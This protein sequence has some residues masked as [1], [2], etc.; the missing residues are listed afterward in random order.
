M[1]TLTSPT[2]LVPFVCSSKGD[3]VD[4]RGALCHA[5]RESELSP[6]A[7]VIYTHIIRPA[8][9][10]ALA[11]VRLLWLSNNQQLSSKVDVLS[12]MSG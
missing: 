9:P 8:L 5:E 10:L 6:A 1:P 3:V 12:S 11:L 7:L 2:F 4:T